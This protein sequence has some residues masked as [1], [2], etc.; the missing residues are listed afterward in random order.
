MEFNKAN[1]IVRA[2]YGLLCLTQSKKC[3]HLS[4]NCKQD[5]KHYLSDKDV[6]LYFAINIDCRLKQLS[7]FMH[8]DIN[9]ELKIIA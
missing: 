8:K 6:G 9:D 5:I 7:Y 4:Y 2:V 3:S 1:I